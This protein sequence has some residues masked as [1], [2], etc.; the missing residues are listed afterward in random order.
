MYLR[1]CFILPR[2]DEITW[3]GG[4]GE[5]CVMRSFI[6]HT[7]RI[8]RMMK[9]RKMGDWLRIDSSGGFSEYGNY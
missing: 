1:L 3:G 5:N 2:R 7:L 6:N 9:S 8:T 4:A